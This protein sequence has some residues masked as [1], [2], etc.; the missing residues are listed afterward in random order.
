MKNE[1][2]KDV[3]AGRV[4]EGAKWFAKGIQVA[5]DIIRRIWAERSDHWQYIMQRLKKAGYISTRLRHDKIFGESV[6]QAFRAAAVFPNKS[7]DRLCE[8]LYCQPGDILEYV[9]REGETKGGA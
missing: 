5:I 8:L 2:Q 7:L 9:P 3:D 4:E 6:M 1:I